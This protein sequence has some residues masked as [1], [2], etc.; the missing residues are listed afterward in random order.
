MESSKNRL[1]R[2]KFHFKKACGDLESAVRERRKGIIVLEN[3]EIGGQIGL[4]IPKP[5][6][7]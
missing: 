4:V 5:L 2:A 7:S 6:H 1:D 3:I